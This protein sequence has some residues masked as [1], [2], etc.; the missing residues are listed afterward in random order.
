MATT[1][2]LD[3]FNDT[4]T[5]TTLTKADTTAVTTQTVAIKQNR[6]WRSWIERKQ[7][8]AKCYASVEKNARRCKMASAASC[9]S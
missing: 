8:R 3:N 6:V 2:K 4:S 1:T 7:K 9:E 5:P